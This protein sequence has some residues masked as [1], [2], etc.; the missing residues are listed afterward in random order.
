MEGFD[1]IRSSYF[2]LLNAIQVGE[3]SRRIVIII[4]IIIIINKTKQSNTTQ[5]RRWYNA[6]YGYRYKIR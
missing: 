3:E 4:I 6:E 5:Y 2:E 1:T